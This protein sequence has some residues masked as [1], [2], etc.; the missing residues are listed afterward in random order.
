LTKAAE[1]QVR[2]AAVGA[3]IHDGHTR[4][5]PADERH[6]PVD[7]LRVNR[8]RQAEGRVVGQRNRFLEILDPVETGDRTEQLA[9]RDFI[10]RPDMLHDCRRDEVAVP[11]ARAR[12]PLAAGEHCRARLLRALHGREHVGHLLLVDDRSVVIGVAGPHPQL[13]GRIDEHRLEPVVHGIEH[14]D[15]ASGRAPLAGVAER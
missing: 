8:R 13:H 1:R 7:V 4:L 5:D 14:D 15:A 10:V 12:Q 3:A 9:A 11:I 2:L 6:G